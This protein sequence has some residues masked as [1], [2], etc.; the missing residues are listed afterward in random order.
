MID[1]KKI[2]AG[3]ATKS[4][5]TW[6]LSRSSSP[7]RRDLQGQELTGWLLDTIRRLGVMEIDDRLA[8]SKAVGKEPVDGQFSSNVVDQRT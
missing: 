1:N 6:L 2:T 4:E 5:R 3:P 8:S 7:I